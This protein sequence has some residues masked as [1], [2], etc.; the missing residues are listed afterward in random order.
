VSKERRIVRPYRGV[1]AIQPA[2]SRIGLEIGQRRIESGG[3]TTLTTQDYLTLP[4]SLILA[5]DGDGRDALASSLEAALHDGDLPADRVELIVTLHT[6]RLKQTDIAWRCKVADLSEATP[7]ITLAAGENRPRALRAP[8][9]GCN[10]RLHLVLNGSLERQALRPWRKGTWLARAQYK[11]RTNLNEIGFTP[12]PL[13]D[14]VREQYGLPA[15]TLRFA[16]IDEPLSPAGGPESIV[17][18]IDEDVLAELANNP[19]SGAAKALQIELFLTAMSA[20]LTRSSLQLNSDQSHL[21]FDDI[22]GSVL[23]QV[24]DLLVGGAKGSQRSD[25]QQHFFRRT[26]RDPALLLAH[27]EAR[28]PDFR[29]TTVKS[30][31]AETK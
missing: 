24:I 23:G 7:R 25:L 4:V 2:I 14:A 13:T 16:S 12:L 5:K 29:S 30:L 15:E 28:I 20:A 3:L 6:P 8:T 10:A 11:I 31:R 1:D 21:T 19:R 9:G 17:L 27:L 22:E 26:K 18:Y